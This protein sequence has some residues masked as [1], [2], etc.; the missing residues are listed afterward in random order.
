MGNSGTDEQ[1]FVDIFASRNWPHLR[2]VSIRYEAA[3]GSLDSD[4]RSEFD[5]KTGNALVTIRKTA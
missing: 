5:S 2:E 3:Y 1:V 4:I